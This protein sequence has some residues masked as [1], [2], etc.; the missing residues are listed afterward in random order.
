MVLWK[1][2]DFFGGGLGGVGGSRGW[3]TCLED[4]T[5]FFY[6]LLIYFEMWCMLYI[7]I[8]KALMCEMTD[9]VMIHCSSEIV[10]ISVS[11][12]SSLKLNTSSNRH[13]STRMWMCLFWVFGRLYS[14]SN[15]TSK[16]LRSACF[17]SYRVQ[18]VRCLFLFFY[19]HL[20]HV[21]M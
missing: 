8:T 12:V 2:N 9:L 10:L 15:S 6:M 7:S 1:G 5:T 3:H 16:G 20:W 18:C 21:I 17:K 11:S 14:N 4:T 13:V 19:I